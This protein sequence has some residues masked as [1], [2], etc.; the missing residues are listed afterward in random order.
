[1]LAENAEEI[2][3]GEEVVLIGQQLGEEITAGELADLLGTINY[4][5]VCMMAHRV[6]RVYTRK[7]VTES[8][9]N[10]LLS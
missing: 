8:V 6:A 4:E 10:P 5:L 7:G 1:S 9:L 2:Q 3:A